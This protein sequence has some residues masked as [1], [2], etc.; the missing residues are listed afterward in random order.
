MKIYPVPPR[1]F[2]VDVLHV[3]PE[4]EKYVTLKGGYH[5]YTNLAW[6]IN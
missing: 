5:R 3:R 4:I 6:R 1:L 2:I